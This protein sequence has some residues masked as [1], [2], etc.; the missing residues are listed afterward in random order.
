M[1]WQRVENRPYYWTARVGGVN[2]Y[3]FRWPS[4]TSWGWSAFAPTFSATSVTD[5][6]YRAAKRDAEA[7]AR[8]LENG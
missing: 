2:Y 3:L 7:F 8:R 4:G 6:P 5:R 1:K